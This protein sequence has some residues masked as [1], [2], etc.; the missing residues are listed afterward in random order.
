[1]PEVRQNT[2]HSN[3]DINIINIP[4]ALFEGE[5]FL[6][7]NLALTNLI[8]QQTLADIVA[9]E[10]LKQV[11]NEAL[12]IKDVSIVEYV[13]KSGTYCMTATPLNGHVNRILILFEDTSRSAEME[14]NNALLYR[15][16]L[17][18][19]SSKHTLQEKLQLSVD[20]ILFELDI[21]D[22]SLMLFDKMDGTL[23]PVAWGTT[24]I[25]ESNISGS[26]RFSLNEGI[27]G[28]VAVNRRPIVVPNIL[29]E[30]QFIKKA[31]DTS[32]VSL[33]C[34]PLVLGDELVGVMSLS[35]KIG[36]VFTD[37]EVQF[38]MAI[39]SRLASQA[40]SD[41]IKHEEILQNQLTQLLSNFH[42]FEHET[43]VI[44]KK[45]AEILKVDTCFMRYGNERHS[46]TIS[47]DADKANDDLFNEIEGLVADSTIGKKMVRQ[48]YLLNRGINLKKVKNTEL[49]K[50]GIIF[51]LLNSGQ[52]KGFLFIGNRQWDR[53]FTE[54]EIALGMSLAS[55]LAI[56]FGNRCAQE[57]ILNGQRTLQQIQDTIRDGLILYDSNMKIAAYN[58]TAKRLLGFKQE[59]IGLP[60]CEVLHEQAN[61]Y[62]SK[63]LNRHF[64]AKEFLRAAVEDGRTSTGLATLEGG[65]SPKTVEITVAPV[66]D[67][68][69]QISGILSHF[70]DIT[71]VHELQTRLASRVKQLTFLFRISSVTGF[72]V[73]QI[74]R[75]SLALVLD[76]LS[77][78]ASQ[79]LLLGADDG[80]YVVESAGN[81]DLLHDLMPSIIRRIKRVV[82]TQKPQ[83]FKVKVAKN[84]SPVQV[85][86]MP[87]LGHHN[88]LLG[89][90][91]VAEEDITQTF[92]KEDAHLLSIVA[93]RIAAKLD[94]AWL[95]NQVEED[96][97]KLAAIIEQSVDGIL[98]VDPNTYV[99]IWNT[100]L[101]RLT[102]IAESEVK[103]KTI[104]EARNLLDAL[105]THRQND[106]SEIK[107]K[108]R[109]TGEAVW[110]GA[111]WSPI[112]SNEET[113][114]YI[115]I[116]RDISRQKELEQAKNEFV[117]TASHELRSP[118][119]AIVGYLSMLKRG[120]A[121]K[122]D[123]PQQAFFIDKAYQ[124]ARRMVGLIEDLLV[125]TRMETGQVRYHIEP[126]D[127]VK[128]IES[129]M[130]DLRFRAEEKDIDIKLQKAKDVDVLADAQGL[131]QILTNLISNAIKYTPP[132][133]KVGISFK[134]E[135]AGKEP[136]VTIAVT[137]TGVGIDPADH[138]KIFEK[139]T[140]IDN[141]LSVNAGGTGLGLYITKTIVGELGGKIWIESKKDNGS[142]LYVRLPTAK[143]G[144]IKEK[145]AKA[146][147]S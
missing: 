147:Q 62:C 128:I 107:F 48:R 67:R 55:Q 2:V 123:N 122:V 105:E 32:P 41:R 127:P 13:G 121:G 45:V 56:A 25:A 75:R 96:R 112:V 117:S 52:A 119:T 54:S 36:K 44:A 85:L 83:L 76:L 84:G 145:T 126:I 34:V 79:L 49:I 143:T 113:T 15:L 120:D 78:E 10:S 40:D 141:P 138:E 20:Q 93:S 57:E 92:T 66:Y 106:F 91:A 116:L 26:S 109:I 118:I 65:A 114:G 144:N 58:T 14:R 69:N 100:A 137:D 110:L 9:S 88:T 95:L 51:P 102:G 81:K 133:G 12:A 99:Q 53:E 135:R 146:K 90:L 101:E 131:H 129:I 5:S 87:V 19:T 37:N 136:T 64:D 86:L 38:F 28:K 68:Q 7:G 74:V 104:A 103:G 3:F 59:I 8:D 39:A 4:A 125:T 111:A 132:Q 71:P 24:E 22:C 82:K 27:A 31:T 72:N 63:T 43:Q 142:T 115:V 30:S 139:F 73:Q 89:V 6:V 33:L 61:K 18:L 11:V 16:T 50:R 47:L 29:T 108:H 98:V 70:R 35:R 1:M 80:V 42:Q 21:F 134:K 97:E 94:N 60:W 23:K 124:N 46:V 140:R 77:V 130:S 17:V